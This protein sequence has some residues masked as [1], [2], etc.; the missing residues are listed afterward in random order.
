MLFKCTVRILKLIGMDGPQSQCYIFSWGGY[1]QLQVTAKGL[2]WVWA[3]L[4][5]W[6]K[7]SKYY[8]T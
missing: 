3:Y 8:C 7:M 1:A 6:Q 4:L 5:Y 2:C